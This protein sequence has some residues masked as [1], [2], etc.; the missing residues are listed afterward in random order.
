MARWSDL[1][2]FDSGG[3]VSDAAVLGPRIPWWHSTTILQ[4]L[5][6]NK[7]WIGAVASKADQLYQRRR[8]RRYVRD[9]RQQGHGR[10]ILDLA[11]RK[12]RGS[13]W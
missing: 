9:L 11:A 6:P 8:R 5:R 7:V 3:D 10:G 4:K 12:H 13:R 1:K 2:K